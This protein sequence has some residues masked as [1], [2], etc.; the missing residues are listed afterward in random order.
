MTKGRTIS[1]DYWGNIQSEKLIK[2]LSCRLSFL[3]LDYLTKIAHRLFFLEDQR[4][5]GREARRDRQRR[6]KEGRGEGRASERMLQV[7]VC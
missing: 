6:G 4:Q 2:R 7:C 5:G 3:L 1:V